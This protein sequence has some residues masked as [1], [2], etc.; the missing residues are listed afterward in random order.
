M[1]QKREAYGHR[2]RIRSMRC[3]RHHAFLLSGC[4]PL[5]AANL[6]FNGASGRAD[7][8]REAAMSA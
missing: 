6:V 3:L 4:K 2:R 8:L 5:S 7:D 1:G